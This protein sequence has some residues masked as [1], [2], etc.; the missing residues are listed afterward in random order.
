MSWPIGGALVVLATALLMGCSQPPARQAAGAS[1]PPLRLP[2]QTATLPRPVQL[3]SASAVSDYD[4][5]R[6]R[7]RWQ[8][9]APPPWSAPA[10]VATRSV[11]APA[12]AR[13]ARPTGMQPGVGLVPG[14]GVSS[15][16]YAPPPPPQPRPAGVLSITQVGLDPAAARDAQVDA[17]DA[18]G[19]RLEVG[20]RSR[21]AAPSLTRGL[22]YSA[23]PFTMSVG[24]GRST[25]FGGVAYVPGVRFAWTTGSPY[26]LSELGLDY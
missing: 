16:H 20:S 24:V 9:E 8:V 3:A 10:P 4:R 23:D 25:G 15:V 17:V 13:A 2:T 11:P 7:D 26:T 12:P 5:E 18:L 6:D 21:A 19:R 22:I 1:R 14:I